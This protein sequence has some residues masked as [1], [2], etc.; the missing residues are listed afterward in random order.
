MPELKLDIE[1][2]G[3]SHFKSVETKYDQQWQLF[4]EAKGICVAR[5]TNE[6]VDQQVDEVLQAIA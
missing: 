3:D 6:Q 4:V 5:F 1:T 2:D